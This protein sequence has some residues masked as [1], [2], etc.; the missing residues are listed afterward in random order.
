[1]KKII[2]LFILF[3]SFA[4]AQAQFNNG[5]NRRQR[6]RDYTQSSDRK[7][8]E[9]KFD[10]NRYLRI[11][12]YDVEKTVKKSGVKLS[13]KEGKQFSKILTDYNKEIKAITRI[14]SFTFKETKNMV[15]GFQ[16]LAM[17]TGDFSEQPNVQKKIIEN[18]KPV[19]N[20][21]K[22]ED[23]SLNKKLKEIL[24]EKQYKKWIKYNKK[25]LNKVFPVE[26]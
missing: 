1:M 25:K 11:V 26:E 22:E 16:K 6:Q 12:V 9:P 10:V 5:M 2:L 13:S 4:E 7:A 17:K 18:L 19:A 15:E 24:T 20:T 21:L 23:L 8:P 14:N 3:L